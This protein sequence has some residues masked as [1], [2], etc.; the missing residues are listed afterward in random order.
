VRYYRIEIADPDTGTILQQWTSLL[1]GKTDPGALDVEFDIPVTLLNAPAGSGYVRLWGVSLAMVAQATAFNPP[2]GGRGKLITVSGG[3]QAGLPLAKPEQARVLITGLIQQ[4]FGNWLGVDM[5]LDLLFTAGDINPAVP[6]NFNVS[7]QAGTAMSV[8]I[9]NA[10]RTVFPGFKQDIVLDPKLVLNHD[11]NG[12]F[13]TIYQFAA[14]VSTISAAIEGSEGVENAGARISIRENTF[15]VRDRSTQ[16]KP[17]Q[18]MFNDLIGQVTWRSTASVSII[19]VMRGDLLV[20]DLIL[21]PAG[22]VT[23]T[24]QSQ[25]QYRQGSA[26][27]GSFVITSVRHVGR[28]RNPDGQAWVSVIE[29]ALAPALPK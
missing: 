22:Q 20:G 15:Y 18:I 4:A 2:P 24:A 12:Y 16:T 28:F 9:G 29:A 27:M 6:H 14:Y 5:T 3:M 7:W 25:S 13:A 11:G 1:G 17:I 21:M 10:L 19:C 23:T 8:M 26:I